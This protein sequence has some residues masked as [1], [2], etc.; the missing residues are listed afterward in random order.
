MLNDERIRYFVHDNLKIVEKRIIHNF[1]YAPW[2]LLVS[3]IRGARAVV[4]P[5][6]Y[7]GFGLPILEAMYLGTPVISSRES[8]VPEIAG[9]AAILVDPY[10]ASEIKRAVQALANDNEL[11]ADLRQRGLKQAELYSMERY[12]ER[13]KAMYS[14]L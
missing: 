6:L 9:E 4:F 11:C 3:L 7:E 2:P 1:Q 5:S 12:R 8:S 13:L 10:N 14:K